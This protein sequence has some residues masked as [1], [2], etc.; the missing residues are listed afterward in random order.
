[1]VPTGSASGSVTHQHGNYVFRARNRA[2]LDEDPL[3]RVVACD[4]PQ[5]PVDVT[6]H[7][8]LSVV[9]DIGLE[10]DPAAC[11]IFAL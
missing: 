2:L 1:M 3:G 11:H 10:P 9:V 8:D 7:V 4:D 5:V 6:V